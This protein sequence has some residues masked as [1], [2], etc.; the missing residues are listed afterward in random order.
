MDKVAIIESLKTEVGKLLV[1]FRFESLTQHPQIKFEQVRGQQSQFHPFLNVQLQCGRITVVHLRL[2][3]RFADAEKAERFRAQRIHQQASGYVRVIRVLFYH[4]P[5]GHHQ[6]CTDV[7]HFHARIEILQC[8]AVDRVGRDVFKTFA[9]FVNDGPKPSGVQRA[10]MP[11]LKG[12]INHRFCR[13][14]EFRLLL[15]HARAIG[16][17]DDIAARNFVLT[18]THQRQLNLILYIFYM[19]G[20]AGRHASFEYVGDLT[21][22]LSDRFMNSGRC[23]R[24]TAF[25]GEISLG[26]GYR[27][28]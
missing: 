9:G 7:F 2:R 8:F 1:S 6:R 5:G 28:F 19:Y 4:C 24:C 18:S 17:V 12:D 11:I 25:H 22:Q 21:A 10:L 3:S 27:D 13:L 26:N 16:P 14:L 23:S 15:A 20:A